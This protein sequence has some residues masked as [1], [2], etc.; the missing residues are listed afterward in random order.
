MIIVLEGISAAG[1][2]T[3][4]RQFGDAHWLP[5]MPSKD[6]RPLEGANP[7]EH[8]TFW[9]QHNI[10]RY[11]RALE[12][13]EEHGFVICDTEPFKL[14]YTWTLA[15]TGHASFAEFDAALDVTR[16]AIADRQLG[17]GDQYYVKRI[18]PDVARAQKEGDKTRRRGHFERHLTLQPALIEWFTA[19]SGVFPDRLEWSF[20]AKSDVINRID[21]KTPEENPRRFDVSA[22]EALL[23]ALPA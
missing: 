6:G 23:A 11:Q 10:N 4:A 9:L 3:F 19:V 17:F 8:A 13:E 14:H 5:E 21:T 20:P 2:S 1:K 18:S 7:S 12:I 22:F 15:R 16:K